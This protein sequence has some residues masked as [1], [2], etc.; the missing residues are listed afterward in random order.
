MW[1]Y[2]TE[3][4]GYK[5]QLGKDEIHS[6]LRY[7]IVFRSF[8]T[9]E[10]WLPLWSNSWYW[11]GKVHLLQGQA[12]IHTQDR[13]LRSHITATILFLVGEGFSFQ[14][15]ETFS[16]R[17]SGAGVLIAGSAAWDGVM[18]LHT[19]HLSRMSCMATSMPGQNTEC[20]AL[21]FM[22][23]THWWPACIPS[24][25]SLHS[26]LGMTTLSQL[27]ITTPSHRLRQ[28]LCF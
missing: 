26:D 5:F 11:G 18:V 28:C 21:A 1:S 24:S 7:L 8:H 19:L 13:N 3:I 9:I 4:Y 22:P 12:R 10:T 23:S 14:S 6:C 27:Y 16:N 17:Y 20:E 15:D 2:I 25:T